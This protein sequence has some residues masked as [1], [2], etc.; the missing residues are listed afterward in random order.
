MKCEW[1]NYIIGDICSS[2]SETYSKDSSKVVLINTS[3]IYNGD[4]LNHKFVENKNLKGQFKK[5]FKTN[6]I[7]FSEIR[8]QNRRFAFIDFDSKDYIASTKLMVLR[9]NQKIISSRYLYYYLTSNNI[10]NELQILAETRSGTFPQIT[11]TELSRLEIKIPDLITQ[12]KIV[13]M[14]DTLNKKIKLNNYINDNLKELS[15]IFFKNLH[16]KS[17]DL[18]K[19]TDIA[20]IKYGK[21]LPTNKFQESGYPVFGGNGIIGYYKDYIYEYPQILIACRGAASGKV[22]ISHPFSFIT[23]NSL[24]LELKDRRY[25]EFLKQYFLLNQF[26]QYKTGSAQPQITI[27]NIK[28]VKIPYPLFSEIVDASNMFSNISNMIYKNDICNLKL[29][30]LRNYLLEKL[31]TGKIDISKLK[32]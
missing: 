2:I 6:D 25:F 14:I 22:I 16:T 1:K 28:H 10:I 15:K 19:I 4:V 7:L 23:N 5:I 8:P 26:Y 3:D 29:I 20:V 13:Y 11:F 18:K 12:N 17:N 24:I 9:A 27:D 30:K 31:V 21:G 32:Y